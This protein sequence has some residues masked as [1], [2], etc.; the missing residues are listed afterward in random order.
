MWDITGMA[1]VFSIQFMYRHSVQGN[2][3]FPELEIK[4][5]KKS[6]HSSLTK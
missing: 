6:Q 3:I 2:L 1:T 4:K 5:K